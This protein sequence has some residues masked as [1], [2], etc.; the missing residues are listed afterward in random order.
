MA[1]EMDASWK[2]MPGTAGTPKFT[3]ADFAATRA[4]VRTQLLR[5]YFGEPKAGIFSPSLQVRS[6]GGISRRIVWQTGKHGKGLNHV[7][8]H[9]RV[10][11]PSRII[12]VLHFRR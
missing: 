11:I 9:R 12:G 4:T 1:T 2:Y 5:A 8:D 3:C 10:A 6:F 7:T